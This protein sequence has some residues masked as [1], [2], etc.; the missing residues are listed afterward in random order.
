MSENR[1]FIDNVPFGCGLDR[2]GKGNGWLGGW[3]DELGIQVKT[4][5]QLKRRKQG[6]GEEKGYFNDSFV[7]VGCKDEPKVKTCLNKIVQING[8]QRNFNCKGKSGTSGKSGKQVRRL[9]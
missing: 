6:H 5:G 8:K 1:Y 2:G 3:L 4:Q 7:F 9:N